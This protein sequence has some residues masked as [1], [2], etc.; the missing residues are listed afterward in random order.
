M[1]CFKY[2][3]SVFRKY[4]FWFSS[5]FAFLLLLQCAGV[6]DIKP[7]VPKHS[8]LS[9]VPTCGRTGDTI[10]IS[11]NNFS[12]IA[13]ENKVTIN[14]IGALVFVASPTFLKAIVPS[15]INS[16]SVSV[17]IKGAVATGPFF[18]YAPTGIVSI[19]NGDISVEGLATDA[20]KSIVIADRRNHTI[21]KMS[22][23]KMVTIVAGG[24]PGGADY[25]FRDG[26]GV[27]VLF[28]NPVDVAVDSKGNIFVSDNGNHCIRKISPNGVVTLYAGVYNNQYSSPNP[29]YKD[30]LRTEAF[31]YSPTGIAIDKYDNLYVCDAGNVRIRKITP[32]NGNTIGKVTTLAGTG[33][34]GAKDGAALQATFSFLKDLVVDA[35]GNIFV[36]EYQEDPKIRKVSAD[37][38]VSTLAIGPNTIYRGCGNDF[39][40]VDFPN[41]IAIDPN[42][43][44][45]YCTIYAGNNSYKIITLSPSNYMSS[46]TGGKNIGS[47]EGIGNQVYIPYGGSLVFMDNALYAGTDY[48]IIKIDFK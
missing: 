46:L 16:G 24:G 40:S 34:F 35:N 48:Q 6:Y 32:D 4:I 25:G 33:D 36:T 12:G 11:G 39:N 21:R 8:I 20:S 29:G 15:K 43:G 18:N 27:D 41:G 5:C 14:G 30:G 17:D 47:R 10:T 22:S 19:I 23:S 26:F 31:F 2:F 28:N 13:A 45:L 1:L 9:I 37:N 7:V 3:K 38:I 44:N 42:N